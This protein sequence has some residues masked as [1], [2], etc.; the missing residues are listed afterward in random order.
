MNVPATCF[1]LI[2]N[3]NWG[4]WYLF[5]PLP[6]VEINGDCESIHWGPKC[7]VPP[8]ALRVKSMQRMTAVSRTR[9]V[10]CRWML[11]LS[12]FH[13]FFAWFQIV[14]II[15]L[16]LLLDH[17]GWFG[18]FKEK[19]THV[20]MDIQLAL[21]F[22]A[23]LY[24]ALVY[25]GRHIYL[26]PPSLSQLMP[27]IAHLVIFDHRWSPTWSD[28]HVWSDFIDVS[29]LKNHCC[30]KKALETMR[31][32]WIIINTHKSL[33]DFLNVLRLFLNL[34]FVAWKICA[35]GACHDDIPHCLKSGAE[36]T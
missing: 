17:V 28:G 9:R 8:W 16:W 24:S 13:F 18:G 27:S 12:C 21:W 31:K 30:G 11:E 7:R 22:F 4:F 19:T 15:R 6:N 5:Q 36:Q 32:V 26:F 29:S 14:C 35:W 1:G 25:G 34:I 23:G 33:H 2:S 10:R 3:S 20:L